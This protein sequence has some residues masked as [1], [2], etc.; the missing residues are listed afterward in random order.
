MAVSPAGRSGRISIGVL[1]FCVVA[2]NGGATRFC[3]NGQ[4]NII[5]AGFSTSD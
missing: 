2:G 5:N 4:V 1:T 3:R